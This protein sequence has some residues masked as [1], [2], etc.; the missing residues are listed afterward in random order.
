M[1]SKQILGQFYTT[2][3]AYILNGIT[4]PDGIRTIIEPFAGN[5]DLLKFIKHPQ[6][7]NI[8]CYD[9]APKKKFIKKRD[10]I[11][12][13]PKYQEKFI[14][15][16]PPYLA[17][18]KSENKEYFDKYN[19]ND[20]Y[21]CFLE[22]ILTENQ[23]LGGII[24]IPLNFWC[25]IR[26]NDIDLRKRFLSA[27]DIVLLNIF[28]ERVFADTSYAICAFQFQPNK[29]KVIKRLKCVVYPSEKKLHITLQN[30]TIGGEIYELP[31][32]STLSVDRLTHLNETSEYKTQ[33]LVKCIDDATQLGL[34]MS[35][36]LYVDRTPNLSARS[37]ATLVIKPKISQ[38]RQ[39]ELVKYFNVFMQKKRKKYHSLFLTQFREKTRKRI[40]FDLVYEIVNYILTLMNQS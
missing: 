24:I 29:D 31:Q 17:R 30:A 8:E 33:I 21:K 15:T 22:E 36:E 39:E 23:C 40:S 10:T 20:L 7:Y 26:K 28:E 12:N 11:A 2:N 16:N 5:G 9:I 4:I 37:Y 27:Y 6:T 14:L 38:E 25:S 34:S 3:Y 35:K 32:N 13:P 19:T 1:T 18:N